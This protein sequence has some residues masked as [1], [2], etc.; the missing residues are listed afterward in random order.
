MDR[1]GWSLTWDVWLARDEDGEQRIVALGDPHY[2]RQLAP[3]HIPAAQQACRASIG[4]MLGPLSH[5]SCQSQQDFWL[6]AMA[7]F[8]EWYCHQPILHNY[9]LSRDCVTW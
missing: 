1:A 3:A 5:R 6:A 2:V 7:L 4:S 9:S 8:P